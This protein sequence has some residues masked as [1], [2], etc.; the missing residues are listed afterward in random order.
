MTALAMREQFAATS[1]ELLDEDPSVA[2]VLAE[3]SA[4]LFS[5][6]AQRHPDRVINVGI[7]EQLALNVGAGIALTGMLRDGEITRAQALAFA[8]DVLH[9]N[10]DRLY[11]VTATP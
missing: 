10:A 4:A 2:V 7:R 1:A 3:I 6:A 9:D 11:H 5:E 8:R